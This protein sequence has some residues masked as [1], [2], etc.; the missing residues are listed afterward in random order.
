MLSYRFIR[1]DGSVGQGC[2]TRCSGDLAG[3]RNYRLLL[4]FLMA[5]NMTRRANRMAGT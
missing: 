4:A 2:Q 5:Q 1:I 3:K